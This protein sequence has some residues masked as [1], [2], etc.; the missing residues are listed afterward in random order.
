MKKEIIRDTLKVFAVGG[1][2]LLIAAITGWLAFLSAVL[3]VYVASCS[4]YA[5]VASFAA[6]VVCAAAALLGLY[7]CG[8]WVV[9][10]GKFSK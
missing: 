9:S 4:G 10:K 3:F 7:V 5:A 1:V 8:R 6:A 2:A